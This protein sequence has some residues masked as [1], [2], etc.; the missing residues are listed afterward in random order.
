MSLISII[1]FIIFKNNKDFIHSTPQT[2]LGSISSIFFV[3]QLVIPEYMYMQLLCLSHYQSFW[4]NWIN[5]E[6][7]LFLLDIDWINSYSLVVEL[8]SILYDYDIGPA[9]MH[10][11]WMLIVA[12]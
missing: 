8:V 12:V 1:L 10:F 4:L 6:L 2:T 7:L 3:P 9:Y 5:N 11:P